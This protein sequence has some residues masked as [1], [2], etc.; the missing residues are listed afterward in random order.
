MLTWHI[1]LRGNNELLAVKH[2]LRLENLSF[3]GR[4]A[5]NPLSTYLQ[6]HGGYFNNR[7]SGDPANLH[8]MI[9]PLAITYMVNQI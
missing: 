9:I 7:K 1:C 3:N 4:L 2:T 5:L 6:I 8:I